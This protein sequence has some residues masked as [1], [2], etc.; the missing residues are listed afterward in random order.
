MALGIIA[1]ADGRGTKGS[2]IWRL[3]R[4]ERD[5][6]GRCNPLLVSGN[7]R[8]AEPSA[9]VDARPPEANAGAAKVRT[10]V[11]TA[12][13]MLGIFTRGSIVV[14]GADLRNTWID[15]REAKAAERRLSREGSR[16]QV[17]VAVP[18]I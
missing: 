12:A 7:A 6:M 8:G 11:G 10:A 14:E 5:R 2:T 13:A 16:C 18:G 1:G 17:L 9:A 15:E 3:K 4:P